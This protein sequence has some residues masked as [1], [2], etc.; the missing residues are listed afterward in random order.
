MIWPEMISDVE[1]GGPSTKALDLTSVR[2]L[3]SGECCGSS[4][5]TWWHWL[6][7]IEAA[8]SADTGLLK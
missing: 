1:E 7:C 4:Q 8:S 2:E 3:Q 5:N 6:R